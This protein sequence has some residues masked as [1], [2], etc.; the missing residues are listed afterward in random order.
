M[1]HHRF[2]QRLQI[3]T[4]PTAVRL[5]SSPRY[6]P[7]AVSP[8][9]FPTRSPPR[10]LDAAAVGGLEPPSE[11]RLRGTYP[12][13]RHSTARHPASRS[14]HTCNALRRNAPDCNRFSL[15]NPKTAF[16]QLLPFVYPIGQRKSGHR[17]QDRLLVSRSLRY[18]HQLLGISALLRL[19]WL[20]SRI[21]PI[22]RRRYQRTLGDRFSIQL[23][24]PRPEARPS[25]RR[26]GHPRP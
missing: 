24:S 16:G 22:N 10:L 19:R 8:R 18:A 26:G 2:R 14:W 9:L 21:C 12:H 4:R 5:R 17:E 1:Q 20:L 15:R 25:V 6:T 7:S 23:R 3:S 11:R 13:L